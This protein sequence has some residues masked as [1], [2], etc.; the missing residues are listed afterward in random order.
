MAELLPTE[1]IG[2]YALP[3]WLCI[4]LERHADLGE[5]DLCETLDDAVRLAVLDQQSAGLDVITDGEMRRRDFIQSFYGRLTGLRTLA[6]QRRFGAAGYDQN[7]RHE[8][9]HRCA[10]QPARAGR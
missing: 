9:A 3:S 6:P 1:L 2:S 8:V 7:P 4:A 10:L 5:L